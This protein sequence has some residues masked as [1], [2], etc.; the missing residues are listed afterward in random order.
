MTTL[1]IIRFVQKMGTLDAGR[2][3]PG[4]APLIL[5]SMKIN[6]PCMCSGYIFNVRC[7]T[8]L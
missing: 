2:C 3:P 7:S 6:I 4:H 5:D 1:E 8:G